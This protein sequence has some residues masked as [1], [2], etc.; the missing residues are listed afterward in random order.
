MPYDP[1]SN[2]SMFSRVMGRLDNQDKTL[3]TILK[4]VR[5]VSKDHGDRLVRLETDGAV[6][7]GQVAAVSGLVSAVVGVIGW[8]LSHPPQ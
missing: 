5:S 3:E 4:E 2:D 6:T 7:R 1:N 8:L